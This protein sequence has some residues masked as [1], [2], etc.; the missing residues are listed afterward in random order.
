M[1]AVRERDDVLG[2]DHPDTLTTRANM[3]LVLESQGKYDEALAMY[4]AVLA[5]REREDVLGP[6]HPDTLTT[7]ANM[8]MVLNSQGKYD[9][10]FTSMVDA[11]T[12][13]SRRLGN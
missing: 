2:P 12:G 11:W 5:V 10:A 8:A 7:R 3:A 9:D 1:G 13:L 6:D 4:E